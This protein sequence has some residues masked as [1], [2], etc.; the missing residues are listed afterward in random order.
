[1]WIR[2]MKIKYNPKPVPQKN[3]KNPLKIPYWLVI[4]Y[5]C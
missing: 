1:M 2:V 4:E 5:L 3:N